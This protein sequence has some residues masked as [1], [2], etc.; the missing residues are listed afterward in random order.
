MSVPTLDAAAFPHLLEAV[1][2]QA[3][4]ASLLALRAASRTCKARAD[5]RLAA[6]LV[7]EDRG[8]G[9][10]WFA[11]WHAS[12]NPSLLIAPSSPADILAATF[13]AYSVYTHVGRMRVLGAPPSD[14]HYNWNQFARPHGPFVKG[15]QAYFSLVR[16]LDLR[17]DIGVLGDTTA[18]NHEIPLTRLLPGPSGEME[19]RPPLSRTLALFP[20]PGDMEPSHIADVYPRCRRVVLNVRWHNAPGLVRA[21]LRDLEGVDEVVISFSGWHAPPN[22]EVRGVVEGRATLL[23]GPESFTPAYFESVGEPEEEEE[24]LPWHRLGPRENDNLRWQELAFLVALSLSCGAK[25]TIVDLE[26]VDPAWLDPDFAPHGLSPTDATPLNPTPASLPNPPD[27]NDDHEEHDDTTFVADHP[28][29][30]VDVPA[31]AHSRA[32]LHDLKATLRGLRIVRREMPSFWLVNG[33][34]VYGLCTVVM[35]RS[36]R[37]VRFITAEQYAAEADPLET[38]A[39]AYAL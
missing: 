8:M 36:T 7:L 32:T 30:L 22:A 10:R 29:D 16:V 2:T 37:G 25:V 14:T 39:S 20:S 18:F 31:T 9:G 34:R 33:L 1:I 6:H 19:E 5:A 12:L 3:P 24:T 4:P 35:P 27:P 17:G 21:R 38:D 13:N 28:D 23:H 15:A 26:R 11:A